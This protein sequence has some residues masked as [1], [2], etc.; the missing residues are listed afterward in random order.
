MLVAVGAERIARL[1]DPDGELPAPTT[2]PRVFPFREANLSELRHYVSD[3]ASEHMPEREPVEELVLAVNE[4][5]TNSVRHGGGVGILRVW[6]EQKA[7]LC[8]VQDAGHI[9]DPMLGR[10]EPDGLAATSRG[11]WIADQFCDLVEIRSRRRAAWCGCTSAWADRETAKRRMRR[12]RGSCIDR[13][14]V[15]RIA[16]MGAQRAAPVSN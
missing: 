7:L 1:G 8:E 11:L 13:P 6:R 16:D 12:R 15:A 14:E 10:V 9:R 5:A 4:I 3:W 2:R